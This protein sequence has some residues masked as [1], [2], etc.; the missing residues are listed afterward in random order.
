MNEDLRK[1]LLSFL[2]KPEENWKEN[3]LPRQLVDMIH[4]GR[5]F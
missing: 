4:K 2:A 5:V 1:E 3:K